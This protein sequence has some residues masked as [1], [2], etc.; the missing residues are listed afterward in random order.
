VKV[1]D[2]VCLKSGGPKMTVDRVY[3]DREGVELAHTVW[4]EDSHQLRYTC[5]PVDAFVK[6]T[7]GSS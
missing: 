4:Y 7:D 3:K 5:L 1:G 2:V 6:V